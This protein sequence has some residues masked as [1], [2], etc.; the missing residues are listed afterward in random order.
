M[1]ITDEVLRT[2]TSASARPRWPVVGAMLSCIVAYVLW[3]KSGTQVGADYW[4]FIF[5]GMIIGSAGMQV[6]LTGV[7]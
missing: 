5:P 4:R 1:D 2:W 7:K 3:I 6:V